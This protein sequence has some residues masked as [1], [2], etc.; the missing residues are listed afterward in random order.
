[1]YPP[2]FEIA[3]ETSFDSAWEAFCEQILQL[4]NKAPEIR[5]RTPPDNGVDIYWKEKKIAYQCK[6]A[7]YNGRPGDFPVGE[8]I[9]SLKTALA[10]KSQIGWEKYI[11]CTN[12]DITGAQEEKIKEVYSDVEFLT[13]GY[14]SGVCRRHKE[15]VADRFR[16]LVR[17]SEDTLAKEIKDSF[18]QSYVTELKKKFANGTIKLFVVSNRR[19]TIF[20]IPVAPE[21]TVRELIE[22]LR[23][24]FNLPASHK[25]IDAQITMSLSYKLKVNNEGVGLLSILDETV[26]DEDVVTLWTKILWRDSQGETRRDIMEHIT[27]NSLQRKSMSQADRK[28]LAIAEYEQYI[29]EAFERAIENILKENAF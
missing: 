22:V 14:W 1:M 18:Y 11:I 13:S 6:S 5:R 25:H 20:E 24:L 7:V 27:H 15:F 3:P 26:K 2:F 23:K 12:I 4:E 9:K 29:N 16:Q 19:K 21:M 10:N 28:N 17:V 8:A